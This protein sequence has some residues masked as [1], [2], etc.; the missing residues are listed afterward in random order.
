ME[1]SDAMHQRRTDQR[2]PPK[3]S[4]HGGIHQLV[5]TEQN[6]IPS[7]TTT[8]SV[9]RRVPSSGK[10]LTPATDA[11]H[12]RD[13]MRLNA[14]EKG[15][16]HAAERFMIAPR[17]GDDR[18]AARD[19]ASRGSERAGGPIDPDSDRQTHIGF[20]TVTARKLGWTADIAA[21]RNQAGSFRITA[22]PP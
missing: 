22:G 13:F 14:L 2:L 16:N 19:A 7:K 18:P 21:S 10:R 9:N 8:E 4:G 12:S 5:R 17:T 1:S 11:G 3:P 6:D 20:L 15:R